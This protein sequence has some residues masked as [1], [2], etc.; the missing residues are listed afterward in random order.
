MRGPGP[1]SRQFSP[2]R[3]LST[4]AGLA[5]DALREGRLPLSPRRWLVDLRHLYGSMR[6]EHARP[7]VGARAVMPEAGGLPIE[8]RRAALADGH[9]AALTAF[10]ASGAR[11][12]CSTSEPPVVSVVLVLHNRAELTFACLRSIPPGTTA[13]VEVVIV[14]NA[15]TDDT[16]LL[17]SRLDGAT[18]IRLDSND[19]FIVGCNRAAAVARGE[20]PACNMRVKSL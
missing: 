7:A 11:L 15:S 13:P 1:E 5:F 18:V 14:D 16:S 20:M 9:R 12:S 3:Y 6:G 10:L 2:V 19:G 4:A 17:L 8:A